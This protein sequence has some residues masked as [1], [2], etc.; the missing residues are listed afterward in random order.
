[1]NSIGVREEVAV[2]AEG[3][4]AVE[5]R[6]TAHALV[7]HANVRLEDAVAA[8]RATTLA[9][10]ERSHFV[11]NGAHMRLEVAL[12]AERLVTLATRV[13]VGLVRVVNASDVLPQV[14]VVAKASQTS[15]ALRSTRRLNTCFL[16]TT[17]D[18]TIGT[19]AA[20]TTTKPVNA[21][22]GDL[23][24]LQRKQITA[25]ACQQS[26]ADHRK[27]FNCNNFELSSMST[28]FKLVVLGAGAVGKS[29]MTVQLVSHHF[30]DFY[31]PTIEDSYRKQTVID[32]ETVQLDILDTA[33]QDEY[34][35]MRDQYM[36]TGQGF[37]LVFDVT[38]RA[39]FDELATFA[40]QVRA[41][42]T[43]TWATCRC[44]WSATSAIW[45]ISAL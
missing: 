13:V 16:P 33:G 38:S 35:A 31:D 40:E 5:A 21:A 42:K 12:C 44:W 32:N 24:P 27:P 20:T 17:A 19:N 14:E 25:G 6:R 43:A 45:R 4:A 29:C 11:V 37:I 30:V 39:T 36:R 18:L 28:E 9:A 23:F 10:L 1:M 26:N 22:N 2:A 41:S 7:H 34:S 3:A 15:R 8:I